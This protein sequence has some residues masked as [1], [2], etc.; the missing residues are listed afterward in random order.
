MIRLRNQT[1][2]VIIRSFSFIKDIKY[3]MAIFKSLLIPNADKDEKLPFSLNDPEFDMN[4]YWG[5]FRAFQKTGNPF[6]AFFSNTR[7]KQMQ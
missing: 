3:I 6:T 4:T 7:I 1:L 5:R 2:Y